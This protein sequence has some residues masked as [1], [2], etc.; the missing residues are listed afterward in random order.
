MAVTVQ[1]DAAAAIPAPLSVK[2]QT[3]PSKS[4]DAKNKGCTA[5]LN[6]LRV[7]RADHNNKKGKVNCSLSL[8]LNL[9][10]NT[11]PLINPFEVNDERPK[12]E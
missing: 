5:V 6:H 3:L 12:I 7:K 8:S 11:S 2:R 9:G 10:L 4:H 1:D